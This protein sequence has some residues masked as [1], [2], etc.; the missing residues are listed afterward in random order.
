M[1]L[2]LRLVGFVVGVLLGWA[3]GSLLTITDDSS[4]AQSSL[5][6][7]TIAI[8]GIGYVLG[9]HVSWA[10][11][12][13][14]RL[15]IRSANVT[16]LVAIGV[17]LGFGGIVSAS[18]AVPL[19][20]LPDPFGKVMPLVAAVAVCALAI[21]TVLLRK[22]D[23]IAPWIP[24][25][26][27]VP[28]LS[29]SRLNGRRTALPLVLDTS[30]I[31]DGRIVDLVQTGFLD[32]QLIVP[33]FVLEEL[34]RIADSKD[35]QRRMRGRRGLETLDRLREVQLD[36]ITIMDVE[37]PD[38]PEVDA[39]I[40]RLAKDRGYR[41]ITNDQNLGRVA[42]LQDVPVLNLNAIAGALR[43]SVLPG[44]DLQLRVVQ[45]GRE[46]GQGVGFL[47]DG[48]MVVVDG[49][50]R[51]VGQETFV[52]VTRMLQTGGG[53]MVFAVPKQSAANAS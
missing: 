23:L 31:I 50:N 40:V 16:D 4:S 41:I 32:G 8:G 5:F 24:S 27:P 45:E 52:T 43:P 20:A 21:V 11:V 9:P 51:L 6:V 17:G 29:E 53:R 22:R 1:R 35:V 3:T 46:A 49:G 13:R 7:I 42:Q 12:R 47:D 10:V 39:K 30:V 36:G 2:A 15:A 25:S 44:E 34:Q 18:L 26:A 38:V 37:V 28:I 48:T 33:R 19:A 14:V